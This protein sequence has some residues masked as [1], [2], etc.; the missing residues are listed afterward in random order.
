MNRSY[1]QSTINN[2]IEA[3]PA[4]IFGQ[5]AQSHQHELEELQKRAWLKQIELLKSWMRDIRGN[6]YF[7]FSIP[8]MGKRVDNILIAN[9]IIF[10]VEFKVGEDQ[11]TRA[12]EDQ[13]ID[14]CLDLLNFHE[15]S[16]NKTIVPVLVATRAPTV[17]NDL[18][19]AGNLEKCVR[20]NAENFEDNI[21]ELLATLLPTEA[22]DISGWEASTYKPTPTIIEAAQA[23]YKGHNVNEISRSD[24]GA[25]NLSRTAATVTRIITSAKSDK[26]KCICFLTGVPG[27][28]KTLAGLNIVNERLKADEDEHSVFLSG[29]GPLVEVLREALT[30]DSVEM[31]KAQGQKL[32]R[33][34]AER[35][36]NSFIQN[37]HHFRD[38][39]LK[40]D[41]API[42]KVV[43][44]DEAQRAWQ[45]E[46]VSKFM[47]TK[48]GIDDF[49][50][51]EPEYLISVMNRH[52]DWCTIVCLIGG[53]QEINTGEA[54][55]SEWLVSLKQRYPDWVV[56]YSD[57]ILNEKAT[58]LND[59]DLLR[60]LA[61]CGRREM[62]LHLAVSVRSFRSEKVALLVESILEDDY[63]I[64]TEVFNSIKHDYPICLTRDI[65]KARTWLRK[66][67]KG[68]ERIGIVASSG[69]RRLRADG[70]DV[71]NEISPAD[72][73]LNGKEDV[74]SSYFL[75]D[76][77]TEFDIQG[78]EIDFAC[79]AWDVNLY[80]TNGW[81]FQSFRGSTWQKIN[82]ESAKRYLLNSYRVLLTR[83]RQG[84]IIY[85]P[86]MD[87][88]DWTRPKSLYDSTFEYLSKCGLTIV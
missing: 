67:A 64:A 62:D 65:A 69:G 9:N 70:I 50:M 11:Y 34:N 84:M 22:I 40:T 55:V 48:K 33:A 30:R 66:C 15:G 83:A 23:L 10:V 37:I 53:G 13:T 36:A 61:G 54:G 5:L 58:Y 45:K 87:N 82:Q 35:E 86:D 39:N 59:E 68:T 20:C 60:W 12:A 29:N 78:L 28:G 85:V 56:F 27:A 7:E 46:Q 14:Y 19:N 24:S 47:R 49:E 80:Y 32:V 79:I 51:S 52:E 73:F 16:H 4:A 77:A 42:E 63:S 74:R 2:F 43:V 21:K 18:R 1:Y 25:I 8:R 72:W 31:A 3:D 75:E 81:N 88:S 44:F 26:R 71:R 38:D 41:K 17:I 6:I 76:V 57:K